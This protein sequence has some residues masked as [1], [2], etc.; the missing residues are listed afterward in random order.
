MHDDFMRRS[1]FIDLTFL[2]CKP[3]SL[4]NATY[5]T[6]FSLMLLCCFWDGVHWHRVDQWGLFGQ[7]NGCMEESHL[8][9]VLLWEIVRCDGMP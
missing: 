1:C 3:Y 4:G 8:V 6:G 9:I 2:I 7:K 5:T